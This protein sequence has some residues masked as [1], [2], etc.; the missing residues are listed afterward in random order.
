MTGREKPT[1]SIHQP[2]RD[3]MDAERVSNPYRARGKWKEPTACPDC[4]AVFQRGRWQWGVAKPSAE[5]HL[6][7]ACQRVRDR[8]AAGQLTMSGPFFAEHRNE[9]VRL[10]L[11]TE[12]RAREQ[13]PLERII[14]MQ[15]EA[16]DRTVVTF[17]DS[18]LTHGVGEALRHAY[19][20][21]LDSRYTDEDDLLRVSWN[22]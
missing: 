5:L 9:I 19:R 15:D 8:V 13:H 22:R 7:P 21:E 2:R 6:C 1:N 18:H 3:K 4:G 16:E 11:N 20:G 12:A 17:T 14:G 10:V